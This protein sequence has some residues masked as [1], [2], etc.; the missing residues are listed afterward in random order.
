MVRETHGYFLR[1][2]DG[3][4]VPTKDWDSSDPLVARSEIKGDDVFG[5]IALGPK[6]GRE[7]VVVG[8]ITGEDAKAAG[9]DVVVLLE[10][11]TA[12]N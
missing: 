3:Q 11:R 2:P 12:P 4:V 7:A 6:K 8:F 9:V 1:L 10:E 5:V